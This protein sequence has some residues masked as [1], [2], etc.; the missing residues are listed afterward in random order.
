L[1][2]ARIAKPPF[3]LPKLDVAGSTAVARSLSSALDCRRIIACLFAYLFQAL[4]TKGQRVRTACRLGESDAQRMR[5]A[6]ARH[7]EVDGQHIPMN[8]PPAGCAT[9]ATAL[10]G[11]RLA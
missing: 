5:A 3:H 8:L 4:E 2:S 9:R 10:A 7:L 1:I 11:N 6:F